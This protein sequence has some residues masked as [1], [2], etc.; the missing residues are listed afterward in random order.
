MAKKSVI[1]SEYIITQE[2]SGSIMVHKIYDNVK[3]S[4]REAADAIGFVFDTN[5]TT[6]QFGSKLCKEYGD[7]KQAKIGEYVI[8]VKPDGGIESYRVYDNTKGALRE[9]NE[10]YDI[11][12]LDEYSSWTTRQFGSKLID[13]LTK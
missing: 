5:W 12:S 8:R 4:L 3:S 1:I 7:G 2:D 6:R 13:V 9:I 11:F 10:K